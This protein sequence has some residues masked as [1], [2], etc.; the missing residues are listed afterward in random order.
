MAVRNVVDLG[1]KIWHENSQASILAVKADTL[2]IILRNFIRDLYT[3]LAVKSV[4]PKTVKDNTPTAHNHQ[5]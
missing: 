5:A 4:A 1:R 3:T 2:E